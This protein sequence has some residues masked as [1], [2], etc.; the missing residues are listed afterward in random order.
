MRTLASHNLSRTDQRGT[1]YKHNRV[2]GQPTKSRL[3]EVAGLVAVEYQAPPFEH[4]CFTTTVFLLPALGM[5]SLCGAPTTWEGLKIQASCASLSHAMAL[6]WKQVGRTAP[7]C[8]YIKWLE[9]DLGKGF[10]FCQLR[11]GTWVLTGSAHVQDS[12]ASTHSLMAPARIS[13]RAFGKIMLG[14]PGHKHFG[15]KCI[16]QHFL[17][18][19]AGATIKPKEQLQK[20]IKSRLADMFASILFRSFPAGNKIPVCSRCLCFCLQ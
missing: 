1:E 9:P 19:A 2:R 13:L 5:H 8:T 11:R 6:Q 12:S 18:L 15:E 3:L 17:P 16:L 4:R 20:Q 14:T 7:F 10:H